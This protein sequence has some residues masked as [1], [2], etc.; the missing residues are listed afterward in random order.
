M[1]KKK[2]ANAERDLFRMFW[3][4]GWACIRSAGSGSTPFPAPDILAANKRLRIVAVEVKL[5]ADEIKYIPKHEINQLISF[6]S[7]FGAEPWIAI[8]FLRMPWVF[9]TPDNMQDSGKNF[10]FKKKDADKFGID[11][12]RFIEG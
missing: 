11:F 5:L 3:A 8:K 2:G 1:S 4:R 12:D 10:S 6:S 7:Y 9:V